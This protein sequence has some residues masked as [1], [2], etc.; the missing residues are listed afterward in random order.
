LLTETELSL[1]SKKIIFVFEHLFSPLSLSLNLLYFIWSV[2]VFINLSFVNRNWTITKKQKNN[3]RFRAPL[4]SPL[5]LSL[6]LSLSLNLL[7]FYPRLIEE[8]SVIFFNL[9]I[10]WWRRCE[11]FIWISTSHI[12]DVLL[13]LN[14]QI[15][16]KVTT[17][18]PFCCS[19]SSSIIVL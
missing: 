15:W 1:R 13:S 9:V 14:L 17:Y 11:R 18:H 6:S 19:F 3:L 12:L 10:C 7:Y 4:L 8:R 2:H 5:S 16:N